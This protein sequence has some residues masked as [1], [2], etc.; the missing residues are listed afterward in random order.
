MKLDLNKIRH[1]V[2][3]LITPLVLTCV[4][5]FLIG[6]TRGTSYN[7]YF[8]IA[9]VSSFGFLIYALVKMMRFDHKQFMD[10]YPKYYHEIDEDE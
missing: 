2:W 5:G 3:F 1:R 8:V 7:I 10:S 6:I 4:F 9:W